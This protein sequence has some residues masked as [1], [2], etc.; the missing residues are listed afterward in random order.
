MN[1]VPSNMPTCQ[2]QAPLKTP[3]AL[4]PRPLSIQAPWELSLPPHDGFTCT[5]AASP[6][7]PPIRWL[8]FRFRNCRTRAEGQVSGRVTDRAFRKGVGN[9]DTGVVGCGGS[10]GVWSPPADTLR[11]SKVWSKGT[12]FSTKPLQRSLVAGIAPRGNSW[13]CNLQSGWGAC[14]PNLDPQGSPF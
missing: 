3:S 2:T 8:G 13:G 1:R 5:S 4:R 14:P 9:S 7:P 10:S 11:I 6:G 12:P